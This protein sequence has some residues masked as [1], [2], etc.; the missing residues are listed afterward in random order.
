MEMAQPDW[1]QD[2]KERLPKNQVLFGTRAGNGTAERWRC[3][4]VSLLWHFPSLLSFPRAPA[5]FVTFCS[6]SRAALGMRRIYHNSQL[7]TA[8]PPPSSSSSCRACGFREL[9]GDI[10]HGVWGMGYGVWDWGLGMGVGM[11]GRD[12]TR[13]R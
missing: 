4:H 12:K 11:G 6:T 10:W 2:A 3:A 8:S 5:L 13:Q 7:P 9:H 1:Q